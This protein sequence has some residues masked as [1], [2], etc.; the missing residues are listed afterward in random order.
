[1]A[2]FTFPGVGNFLPG[3]DDE[4]RHSGQRN[5]QLSKLGTILG[6]CGGHED[7]A[8]QEGTLEAARRQRDLLAS[9]LAAADAALRYAEE[10]AGLATKPKKGK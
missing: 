7:Q 5:A 1:M 3:D 10:A 2:K 4:A 9:H 6:H 8:A